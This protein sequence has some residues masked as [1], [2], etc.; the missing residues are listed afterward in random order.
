MAAAIFGT[1]EGTLTVT[2]VDAT[3]RFQLL[4]DGTVDLLA[5]SVSHT[6]ERDL[7]EVGHQMN[8]DFV[9]MKSLIFSWLTSPCTRFLCCVLPL[10]CF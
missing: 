8:L 1:S 5:A 9:I 7:Y 4:N 3:N 6:M 10:P 2:P